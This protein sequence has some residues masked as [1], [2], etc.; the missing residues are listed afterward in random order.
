MR[1]RSPRSSSP[2]TPPTRRRCSGCPT[3]PGSVRRSARSPIVRLHLSPRRER[4]WAWMLTP[5]LLLCGLWFKESGVLA[6]V[7]VPLYDL[8]A[9][10]DRGPRRVWR[11]RWRYA[12]L[13]P[14]LALY[15]R[16]APARARR[17]A[18]GDSRPSPLTRLRDGAERASA[19]LPEYVRPS[20]GRSISTCTT[21]STPCT[22]W[23]DRV[24]G[25]R[26]SSSRPRRCCSLLPAAA[27]SRVAVRDRSGRSSPPRRTC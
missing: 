5:L 1:R 21:T 22:G 11:M 18:A 25:R 20:S 23:P 9:A 8:L 10:A 26:A 16:P 3:S 4:W 15:L 12:V 7:M 17:R 13:L 27:A 24:C 14:P 19:L 2:F 6:L